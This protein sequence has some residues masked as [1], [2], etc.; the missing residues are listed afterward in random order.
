MIAQKTEG[1]VVNTASVAAF[2]SAPFS[3][4]YVVSKCAA[5]SLTECLAHDL[6][7][8]GAKIGASVLVPSA[9]DTTIAHSS[10]VR[11]AHFG[12]DSTE[13]DKARPPP[14]RRSSPRECLPRRRWHR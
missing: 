5:R 6:A 7:V 1:H 11:P 12:V 13:T 14:W 2:V 10:A 8:V 4:P 3:G 9:F